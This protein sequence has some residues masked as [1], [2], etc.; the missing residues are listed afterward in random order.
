MSQLNA[1]PLFSVATCSPPLL[2]Q[3]WSDCPPG[4]LPHPPASTACL[5][6]SL[7]CR[8]L[9]SDN[10]APGTW[11]PT[12]RACVCCVPC[13]FAPPFF[14]PQPVH[15]SLSDPRG[16]PFHGSLP[17]SI[18]LPPSPSCL[19]PPCQP[20]PADQ[21]LTVLRGFNIAPSFT[22]YLC[23]LCIRLVLPVCRVVYW[24]VLIIGVSVVVLL[25]NI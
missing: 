20:Q 2:S 18:C 23:P 24:I 22:V 25:R 5:C 14:C 4:R 19:I 9:P 7:P 12:P 15:R 11:S 3:A 17:P 13:T 1:T 10:F 8:T 6:A 16:S 21:S